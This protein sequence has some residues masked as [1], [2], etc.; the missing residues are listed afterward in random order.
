LGGGFVL[1]HSLDDLTIRDVVN[2]VDPLRRIKRCPLGIAAHSRRL[3]PLH[4]RLDQGIAL[5]DSFFG[6]TTLRELLAEPDTRAP[7]CEAATVGV[8]I[9]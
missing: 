9:S 7:L 2:A 4:R 1:N 6:E 8:A 3:C 5:L